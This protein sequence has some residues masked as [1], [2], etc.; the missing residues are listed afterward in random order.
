MGPP[1]G[2]TIIRDVSWKPS[3]IQRPAL[4]VRQA[5]H[6]PVGDR[7]NGLLGD[8]RAVN[9][10]QVRGDLPVGQPFR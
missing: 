7:G 1:A 3:R 5:L 4:P 2:N 10:G 6:H 9:L 8:L